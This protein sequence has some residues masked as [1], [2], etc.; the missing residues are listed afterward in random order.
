MGLLPTRQAHGE[1]RFRLVGPGLDFAPMGRGNFAR[2]IQSESE[3]AALVVSARP[4]WV[5]LQGIEHLVQRRSLDG[6]ARSS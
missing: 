4:L 5:A 1:H 3:A 6:G 2:D